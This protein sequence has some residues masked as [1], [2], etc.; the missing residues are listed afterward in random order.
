[1]ARRGGLGL[2]PGSVSEP[3]PLSQGSY[4]HATADNRFLFG[5]DAEVMNRINTGYNLPGA[6]PPQMT[7]PNFNVTK[8]SYLGTS[9]NEPAAVLRSSNPGFGANPRRYS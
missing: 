6:T 5:S 8:P 2:N 1:M 7:A 3:R 9:A 4:G